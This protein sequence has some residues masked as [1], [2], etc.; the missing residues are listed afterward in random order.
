MQKLNIPC[1]KT[2]DFAKL[3][4]TNKRTL[5][6]Y[7]EIGL[8]SPAYTDEKG[9]RYYSESQCD[10]FF[11]ITCLREIGMPLKE[12]KKYIDKRNPFLLKE[13]LL[14][15]E[16]KVASELARIER[17]Q[18]VIHTKLQLVNAGELLSEKASS[19]HQMITFEESPEEYLVTSPFLN[20]D[21]HDII[22]SALCEHIGYC[23]HNSLNAGHPYGAM[24]S[25]SS[26]R[27]KHWDN[28]AYFFTKVIT[29]PL[30]HPHHCKPAGL[31]AVAYLKGDYYH[32]C[33]TYEQ[34]F[35]DIQKRELS[36][37]EFSYKEAVLDEI[38][39]ADKADYI[40]KISIPV[41]PA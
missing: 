1:I 22:M 6:H 35:Q 18:Q 41:F 26:L 39:V 29:P 21:D 30:S 20:T 25:I 37:G 28:Y 17:I 10:V 23:S 7:D 9:Y 8:F 12:I 15:Q 11:T 4:N 40:T 5:F 19:N 2:G 24:Q 13:L 32:A 14:E 34:L 27:E 3:C 31:Y 16:K 38:A 33:S 36:M